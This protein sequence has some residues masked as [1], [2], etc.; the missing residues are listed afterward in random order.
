VTPGRFIVLEGGDASGKSTQV[1]LL[2]E[3]LR[4]TGR[5]VVET[6]E[7][8][9]SEAGEVI[10]SLLLDRHERIDPMTEALLLAADRAQQVAEIV[11]PAIARGD[12]VVSDR[13]IPSS[14]AYQ[15]IARGLGVERVEALNHWATDGL[16]P[17]VVVVLD[18][19]EDAAALRY[20]GAPDRMEREGADF[21]AVVRDAYRDLAAERG[22]IVVDASRSIE[23]VAA[24]VWAAV[25]ES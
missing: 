16:E 13:Y 8:G 6:F 9:H 3:R 10:R 21:H 12:D 24:S 7:P 22:W 19:P 17:D 1:R 25:T 20:S 4:T 15:G 11:R 23:E 5:G 14:L 2:V 18:L